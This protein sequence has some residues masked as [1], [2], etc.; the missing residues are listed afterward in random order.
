MFLFT[1]NANSQ[2]V[3]YDSITQKKYI[4]IDVHKT[5]EKVLS[6]GY[7]SLEMLEYLGDYYFK[8]KDYEKS[9]LYFDRLF[10]KYQ[11]SQISQKSVQQYK[12]LE[13]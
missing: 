4:L 9:K 3:Y 8:Y 13:N 1:V 12:I 6:K 11:L 7:E 10:K 2:K 5:Y